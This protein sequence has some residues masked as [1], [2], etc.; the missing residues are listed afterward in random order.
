M[1]HIVLFFFPAMLFCGFKFHLVNQQ[2]LLRMHTH[3]LVLYGRRVVADEENQEARAD[4]LDDGEVEVV[5]ATH[6]GGA[7]GGEHTAACAESKLGSHTSQAHGQ[8]PHQAPE[9][10]LV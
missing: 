6:C 2:F 5:D 7:R 3:V 8:P 10:P 9:R 4:E 1:F